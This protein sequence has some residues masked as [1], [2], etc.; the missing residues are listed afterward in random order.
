MST[1]PSSERQGLIDAGPGSFGRQIEAVRPAR[2]VLACA[3]GRTIPWG[4]AGSIVLIAAI[5]CLVTR[6]WL[7]LTDPVSLSWR[8]SAKAVETESRGCDLL[9]L[10]D[11]QI[12]HGLVPG[13]IEQGTGLR[14]VNLS[15]A[16]APALLTYF[17]LRRAL[18]AGARPAAL[19]INAKPAVLLADPNFNARYWQEVLTPRE[20]LEL[21]QISR[22]P[23]LVASMIVGR[24][25]PS[26][27]YRLEVRSNVLAAL[28]GETDRIQTI[29]RVL[30]RNWTRNGGANVVAAGTL[31]QH[32]AGAS[33]IERRLHPGFFHVDRTNAEAV[34][35][36]IRLAA[37]R[38]IPVFWLLPPS[39][40]ALQALR[41]QS[42]AETRYEQFV[43]SFMERYPRVLT[44]LDGRRPGYPSGLFT[45]LTHLNGPGAIALSRAV[46]TAIPS[47]LS[48]SRSPNASAW[49]A[50]SVPSDRP[51]GSDTEVED[52]E[53]SK[54]ILNLATRAYV[55]SR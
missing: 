48:R 30:L 11:S 5:E 17:L 42:G 1:V 37:E 34:E 25:L 21:L 4:F 46:A 47:A 41:D 45:D 51:A 10:G 2:N 14:T 12:K 23:S 15:A 27:R 55:S 31:Q 13:A 18:D 40:P 19:I 22:N 39:S 26:L 20:S 28:R 54:R 3:F 36:L 50:L 8:Y 44:V 38:D 49:I 29:N 53:Q 24:L 43:R 35:R 7:D 16:R 6:N 33:E 32:D 52:I 9:C